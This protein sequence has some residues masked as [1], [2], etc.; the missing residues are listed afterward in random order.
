[1]K[2]VS[3]ESKSYTFL[4]YIGVAVILYNIFILTN[5]YSSF[6][7]ESVSPL[8]NFNLLLLFACSIIAGIVAHKLDRSVVLWV[9]VTLCFTSISLIILGT[10]KLYLKPELQKVYNKYETK[11][12]WGKLKLKREFEND[13][14]SQ[15]VYDEKLSELLTNLNNEMNIELQNTEQKIID[16]SIH[17][18]ENTEDGI[19]I[20]SD[21]ICPICGTT[22]TEI[23]LECPECGSNNVE[24]I[25]DGK[26]IEVSDICPAC[27]TKLSETDFECP[28]CGLNL[29]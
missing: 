27:G 12:S 7:Q 3:L 19:I 20:E 9:I 29:K 15:E 2:A 8:D 25:K 18:V 17:Q 6:Y 10:K 22:L 24:E 26:I 4:I 5:G 11:Y 1:M 14:L 23:D 16:G 21:N 13:Q 28:E